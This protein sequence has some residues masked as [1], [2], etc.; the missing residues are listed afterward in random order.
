MVALALAAIGPAAAQAIP[1]LENASPSIDTNY[2]LFCIRGEASEL[3]RMV[4]PLG[5]PQLKKVYTTAM[6][7]LN[8]L[9]AK[10][11]PVAGRIR[12]LL[13]SQPFDDFTRSGLEAFLERVKNDTGAVRLLG[14]PN[15]L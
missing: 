6:R 15:G 2:A 3:E 7:R 1:A 14:P 10:A 5:Y 11:K 9:G 13:E 8:A 4:A 12:R